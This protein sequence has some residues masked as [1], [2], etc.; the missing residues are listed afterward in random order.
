M[1]IWIHQRNGVNAF[2]WCPVRGRSGGAVLPSAVGQVLV[3]WLSDRRRHCCSTRSAARRD[4]V[5]LVGWHFRNPCGFLVGAA[6]LQC[7]TSRSTLTARWWPTLALRRCAPPTARHNADVSPRDRSP[8][9]AQ[10]IRKPQRRAVDLDRDSVI[11]PRSAS[12]LSGLRRLCEAAA[13]LDERA[14]D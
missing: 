9:S 14:A 3:A 13:L 12:G 1:E 6:R 11:R 8:F 10:R 4:S 7:S 2:L 5:D